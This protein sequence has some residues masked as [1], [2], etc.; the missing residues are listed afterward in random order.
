MS[1]RSPQRQHKKN[2]LR[3]ATASLGG[4][5]A[6]V[7]ALPAFAQPPPAAP[8]PAPAAPLGA[9]LPPGDPAAGPPPVV[10][11]EAAPEGVAGA[12]AVQYGGALRVRWV[13]V[14]SW[15]L[16]LFT[17]K[18][19]PLSSYGLGAEFFRRKADL[20]I[21][22]GLSYQ[23]MGPPDGNWLGKGKDAG[24][25]TDFISFRNF[26]FIGFDL[27]FIWRQHLNEYL[28][29]HYGAGL[30]L[31]IVTGEML[32]I[33]A[34]G[35]TKDNVG[36]MRACAPLPCKQRGG[37]TEEILKGTEGGVD[38][39]PDDPHRFK[40]PSV[41]GAIPILNLLLGFNLRF[42]ELKGFEMRFEGGFYNA[43][44]LG[45]GIGYAY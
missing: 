44:F 23:K 15:F 5:L 32:R 31:A 11:A 33:S 41:P 30:G 37:C 26:G 45:L 16:G 43:F 36:D 13:S 12:P 24:I 39:G 2:L 14:P 40:E 4:S 8:A 10:A 42:P 18:N 35:C 9:P 19:V 25:D 27:A 6:V 1:T 29:M 34:H 21:T 3:L 28:G 38:N 17:Q 22:L 7:A 20:D